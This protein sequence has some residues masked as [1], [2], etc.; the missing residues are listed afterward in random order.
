ME[1]QA[2]AWNFLAIALEAEVAQPVNHV[3][4][5]NAGLKR[6]LT[7]PSVQSRISVLQA[8]WKTG[9]FGL[10]QAPKSRVIC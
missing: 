5:L 6:V 4:Q 9:Y 8:S 1:I 7:R 10:Q 3:S 2:E